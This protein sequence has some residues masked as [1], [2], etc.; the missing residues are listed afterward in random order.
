MARVIVSGIFL[1][2]V[3]L[4]AVLR[5][6]WAL[7]LPPVIT[8]LWIIHVRRS[9]DTEPE[10]TW[11][12]AYIAIVIFYMLPGLVGVALGGMIRRRVSWS[13][14]RAISRLG[15]TSCFVVQ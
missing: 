1:I 9:T 10:V 5:S 14:S 12:W 13:W 8:A 7:L 11:F 2:G 4:G 15:A 3:L 6:Y